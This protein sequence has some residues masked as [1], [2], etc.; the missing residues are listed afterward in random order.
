MSIC[1]TVYIMK[2]PKGL[3]IFLVVAQALLVLGHYA[4]YSAL[5]TFF[6]ALATHNTL[7]LTVLLLLSVSFLGTS[8]ITF[9]RESIWLRPFYVLSAAWLPL[10]FY[11]LLASLGSV[12]INLP[13]LFFGVAVVLEV[14]GI[15]NAR[16]T[17][18]TKVHVKLRNL[19][20][21]WKGRT[22]VLVTDLHLGHILREGFARKVIKNINALQPDIVFIPGDF[23]DGVKTDFANLAN[24]FREVK[25]VHGIYFTTGNHEPI[26]GYKDC[27]NAISGAGMHIL[28]NHKTEIQG[29]QIAGLAYHAENLET[30]QS[31]RQLLGSLNLD[32]AKPTILLK[33]VPNQIEAIASLGLVDL[34]LSGHTHHGQMWPFRYITHAVYKGFDYGLKSLGNY[35]I[36][37]SS[38][39]GTWGP[40]M[41]A[42]TKSE[43]VKIVFE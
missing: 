25:S 8:I 20:S 39:A 6:P 19:P 18:I 38:G 14:Y 4:V 5:V 30:P 2:L 13:W 11:F 23:Y 9:R 37:T 10:F 41:R 22:A 31:L 36:Y 24:L 7:V 43:V 32:Q 28:E 27:E 33:H 29:L 42:F 40:P 3:I 17:R 35:Q 21:Y 15:I 12:I 1:Y 34:Q 26:A 16:I